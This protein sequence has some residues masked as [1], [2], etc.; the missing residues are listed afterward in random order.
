MTRTV[1][2]HFSVCALFLAMLAFGAATSRAD[3]A[4]K[5]WAHPPAAGE[6]HAPAGG[7]HGHGEKPSLPVD[8]K[9][10]LALWS[11]VT[12]VVFFFV[13]SKIAWGPLQDGLGKREAAIRKEIADAQAANAKAAAL[14]R[15]HEAKLAAVQEEVKGILAEARRDAEHTKQDI[16]AT[17]Q[18][19]AEA[20]RQRAVED[21]DRAKNVAIAELFDFVSTN[22]VQ[23]TEQVL[24]RSLSGEDQER[25]VTQA[26]SEMNLR[27]N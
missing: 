23:A 2:R 1:L 25:L 8:F 17:A 18:R 7:D 20:T 21:I 5:D 16:V 9:S 4:P 11:L 12:F 10:D 27:R 22:V 6:S 13:L 3:E 26:L 19:E 14:L 15:E 24:Q